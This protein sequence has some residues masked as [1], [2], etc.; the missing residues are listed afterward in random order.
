[1]H[2][3][4]VGFLKRQAI[5]GKIGAGQAL[6]A[7]SSADY[8]DYADED[9]ENAP[10]NLRPSAQSAGKRL[11]YV[12]GQDRYFKHDNV[13]LIHQM[14]VAPGRQRGFVG[15]TLLKA[16]FERASYGCLLYSCWC[17]QD[18]E[19][20]RFWEAMGFV[21]L[22]YRAGSS[23][24]GR[25]HIFWQ[26]R[27]REGDTS[28]PWWYPCETTGGQMGEGR[29]VLPIPPGRHWSQEL[30]VLRPA[31]SNVEGPE[32]TA[33]PALASEAPG[34]LV[35]GTKCG[36]QK[37][38]LKRPKVQFGV[39]SPKP[40]AVENATQDVKPV[41]IKREKLKCDPK[42]V[43][44]SREFRDRWLEK[45]NAGE[46]RLPDGG[47][48]DVSRPL[49]AAPALSPVEGPAGLKALPQAA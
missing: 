8:A 46:M 21:P 30:P 27:I 3:K 41:K 28:S 10:L 19:A 38:T 37:P 12:M 33:R 47:K 18:I 7:E 6:I 24:K 16:L 42:L 48:Y 22:A 1:M 32:A 25:V 49:P 40:A 29:I 11:G 13:G 2:S 34:R 35:P 23:K 9:K 36:P 17:A 14:S 5:E 43:A 44:M 15:A 26:K 20:N 39:P 31:L 45:V 4:Q